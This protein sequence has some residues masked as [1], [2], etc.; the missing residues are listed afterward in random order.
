MLVINA[1]DYGYV[2]AY[3]AGIA[4]AARAGAIDGAS[5]MAVRR[6]DPRPLLET[7]VEIGLHLEAWPAADEQVEA[8]VR[9]VRRPPAYIDGHHH[10]HAG[11]AMAEDVAALAHRLEVPVR[12]VDDRHRSFLR[13]RGV[14]TA[15]LLVGRLEESEPALPAEIAGWLAGNEGPAGVTEWFVH[16][17]HP[18]PSAGSAY[19]GG[20]G[21]DLALLLELGDRR[22]WAERGIRRAPLSRALR[23]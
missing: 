18:E 3:D 10:V 14:A 13:E 4:Y 2:P 21:E 22:R 8:F 19:D 9:L 23:S 11:E 17:G 1:D 7:E 6:P 12:S 5:I 16:P 15:D 20:R